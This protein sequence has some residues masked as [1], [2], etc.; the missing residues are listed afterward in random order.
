[1]VMYI[2]FPVLGLALLITSIILC[3]YCCAV[4]YKMCTPIY[5]PT[6]VEDCNITITNIGAVGEEEE[7]TSVTTTTEVSDNILITHPDSIL[8]SAPPPSYDEALLSPSVPLTP[9]SPVSTCGSA[10]LGVESVSLIFINEVGD[11]GLPEY[12]EEWRITDE[13]E[14]PLQIDEPIDQL[15]TSRSVR[16]EVGRYMIVMSSGTRFDDDLN[17]VVTTVTISCHT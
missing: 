9:P 8:I 16:R 17:D 11:E 2:T 6:G 5:D 10:I 12:Q 7:D 1:M 15:L 3:I 4:K 13:Q 14:T